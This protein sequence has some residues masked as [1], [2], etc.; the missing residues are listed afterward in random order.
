M[1]SKRQ[2]KGKL[3][4]VVQIRVCRLIGHCLLIVPQEYGRCE[5]DRTLHLLKKKR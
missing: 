5:R 3:G 1:K 2:E 4:H